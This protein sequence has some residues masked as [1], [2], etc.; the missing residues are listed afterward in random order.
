MGVQTIESEP[1]RRVR[2]A[3]PGV[4]W[5]VTGLLRNVNGEPIPDA[6]LDV[7]HPDRKGFHELHLG[8]A[9]P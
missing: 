1:A 4:A 5:G 2:P 9:A 3:R 6:A 7:W 8:I